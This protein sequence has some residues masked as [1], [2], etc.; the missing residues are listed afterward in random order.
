MATAWSTL[1]FFESIRAV[2]ASCT[3]GTEAATAGLTD[4]IDTRGLTSVQA[5]I[6]T[7]AKAAGTITVAGL[8]PGD[9]VTVN[10]TIFTATSQSQTAALS[11]TQFK[12]MED[13]GSD[14]GQD[15]FTARNLA[16]VINQNATVNGT[17]VAVP[18]PDGPLVNIVALADGTA[19]NSITLAS[20]SARAVVSGATLTGGAA[21]GAI[22]AAA[23]LQVS[24]FN[25]VNKRWER[26][27]DLDMA[28]TTG[29]A[30]QAMRPIPVTAPHTRM[31]IL[32]NAVGVAC[33][34]YHN[35][36]AGRI[37]S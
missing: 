17:L 3:T 20:S 5:T 7:A 24:L 13:N 11:T 4:G 22:A 1:R 30:A 31:Q 26:A 21:A 12:I 9:T 14:R 6:E 37:L 33:F 29:L 19:G 18:A 36:A 2:L 25:P 32:P 8:K 34:V 15:Q 27:P 10:G 23:T 16:D 28:L 35:G